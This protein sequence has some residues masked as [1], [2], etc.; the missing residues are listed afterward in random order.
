M[1]FILLQ[2]LQSLYTINFSD[3]IE[4]IKIVDQIIIDIKPF[5]S[6]KDIAKTVELMNDGY[7]PAIRVNEK[8]RTKVN[9]NQILDVIEVDDH[10]IAA[11]ED[12]EV[13]SRKRLIITNNR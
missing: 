8:T 10:K 12:E 7:K 11:I 2:D 6:S 9:E 1:R 3:K 4:F 5:P 13:I